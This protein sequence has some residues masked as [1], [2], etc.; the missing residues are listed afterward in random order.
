MLKLLLIVA[1]EF[2][3]LDSVSALSLGSSKH[4]DNDSPIAA[5]TRA[6]RIVRF[7]STASGVNCSPEMSY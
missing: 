1:S 4:A 6:R 5:S 7:R 3:K 2:L